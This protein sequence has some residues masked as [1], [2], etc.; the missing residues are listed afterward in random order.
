MPHGP[1]RARPKERSPAGHPRPRISRKI[2]SGRNSKAVHWMSARRFLPLPKVTMNGRN[3]G[4]RWNL[5]LQNSGL[6]QSLAVFLHFR[7]VVRPTTRWRPRR[8]STCAT[9]A[10][11]SSSR[12]SWTGTDNTNIG[13]APAAETRALATS[14]GILRAAS[15]R[16]SS[17]SSG[18]D[19]SSCVSV[20]TSICGGFIE[21]QAEG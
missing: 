16:S 10:F 3:A 13:S 21:G 12:T 2:V 9:S 19:A 5:C 4:Q 14:E 11:K 8:T 6:Q 7:S 17:L 18:D 15:S 20:F 1:Q